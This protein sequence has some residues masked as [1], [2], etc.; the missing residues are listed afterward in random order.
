MPNFAAW[1]RDL[2]D[3][4]AEDAYRRLQAQED[5]LEQLRGDLKDAMKLLR[6]Q[7]VLGDPVSPPPTK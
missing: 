4:F 7:Q 6:I 1:E 5:A 3:K 2:L